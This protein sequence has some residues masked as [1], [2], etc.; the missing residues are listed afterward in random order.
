MGAVAEKYK[1]RQLMDHLHRDRPLGQIDMT[2]LALFQRREA[3]PVRLRGI[4]MTRVAAQLQ[5][6]VFLVIKRP[7]LACAPQTQGKA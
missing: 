3:R 7:V 6:R 2:S 5:R 1:V 4:L